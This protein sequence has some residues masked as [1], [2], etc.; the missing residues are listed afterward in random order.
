MAS[1][2]I[3]T[4]D[5]QYADDATVERAVAGS[6]AKWSIFRER[7]AAKISKD[8]WKNC[9][10]LVVWHEMPLD[11]QTIARLDRCKIIV[12]AGVGFD[13]IDL[14][15]AAD[16]GIPVCNTPDYGTSEVADHAI[17]MMLNFKRGLTSY[18]GHLQRAPGDG[19]NFRLAPLTGRLRGKTLG[20]VGLGR[21]GAA[22][23]LRAKAFGMNVICFDP[24]VSRG[25]EIAVG[26]GR[27]ESLDELLAASDVVSLHCP[28]TSETRNMINDAALKMMRPDAL[29]INTARGAIVDVPALL[30]A[31]RRRE[32]AGAA[33]DV[34]P[35]EPPEPTDAIAVEYGDPESSLAG[36]RLLL[37]PHAA[38]SSPESVEDARRLAVETALIYLREGRLRNLVNNPTERSEI[39]AA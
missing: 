12:R 31:L 21:I 16:R 22:T 1:F 35:S 17:A 38:W 9:D 8:V 6:Q 36:E 29:L 3:L 26:V 25:A 18:H 39:E 30:S 10:A 28:L 34:L 14:E 5:A 37:S 7:D 32:I 24:H 33:L 4:P 13:H 15:A 19:F 11:A 23:A 27:V 20:I 2:H